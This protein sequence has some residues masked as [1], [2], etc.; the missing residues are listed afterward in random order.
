MTKVLDPTS[1]VLLRDAF[2]GNNY[3]K[4]VIIHVMMVNVANTTIPVVYLAHRLENIF[5]K[6]WSLSASADEIPTEELSFFCNRFGIQYRT[7]TATSKT[8]PSPFTGWDAV[9]A[10]PWTGIPNLI[11]DDG[12]P[13]LP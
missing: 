2:S 11:A 12:K 10:R 5:V 4:A 9:H 7:P 1:A 6:S 3:T 13:I 8:A